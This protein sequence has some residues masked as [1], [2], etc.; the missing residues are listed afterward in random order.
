VEALI[1][2]M[3]PELG[4]ISPLKFIPMAEETGLIVPIGDWA[5]DTAC[6]QNKAWQD[7]GFAPISVCVNVSARQFKEKNWV[8]RVASILRESGMDPKYLELEVTES[9][10]M[11]DIEQAIATMKELQ[12][13]GVQLAIDDFG[14]GYSSLAALKRF[15][16]GRLKIDKS[17]ID[18][19]PHD[20]NDKA[21][22][23]A[24]ISL[25]QSLSLKV[26]AEG[27]ETDAQVAFLCQNNCEEIQ[28]Y[29]FSRP[30][31]AADLEKLLAA[32]P[33]S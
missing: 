19:I 22:A 13:L 11:Q 27:V 23:R 3:H 9:L 4:M 25:G 1:R 30:V 8:S 33:R 31:T 15:P 12:S 7:A 18:E 5:L 6:R 16:V 20:E 26:I 32:Q 24:V 28:G 29:H 17:F 2:W 10:I 21:V 14:T